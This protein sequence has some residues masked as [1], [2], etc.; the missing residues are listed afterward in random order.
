M[1][2]NSEKLVNTKFIHVPNVCSQL[3]FS[4][5][6]FVVAFFLLV[7]FCFVRAH[8][9]TFPFE[10]SQMSAQMANQR[11]QIVLRVKN[12]HEI[13]GK[14]LPTNANAF[15]VNFSSVAAWTVNENILRMIESKWCWADNLAFSCIYFFP[16]SPSRSRYRHSS[17]DIIFVNSIR[18]CREPVAMSLRPNELMSKRSNVA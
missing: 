3:V 10:L 12:S 11:W 7:C 8:L 1:T 14:T 17:A 13:T 4:C 15:S 9:A 2:S 5:E 16:S 6:L 18:L